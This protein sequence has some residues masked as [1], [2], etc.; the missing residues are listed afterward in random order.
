MNIKVK[1]KIIISV[2][3]IPLHCGAQEATEAPESESIR[4]KAGRYFH[5]LKDRLIAEEEPEKL[6][7]LLPEIH[8]VRFAIPSDFTRTGY[9]KFKDTVGLDITAMGSDYVKRLY[10][11]Q[12]EYRKR[13]KELNEND[14]DASFKGLGVK[15]DGDDCIFQYANKDEIAQSAFNSIKKLQGDNFTGSHFGEIKLPHKESSEDDG[16]FFGIKQ[17]SAISSFLK[18]YVDKK[19]EKL[20]QQATSILDIANEKLPISIQW[21]NSDYKIS[22]EGKDDVYG[23]ISHGGDSRIDSIGGKKALIIPF[24][25]IEGVKDVDTKKLNE[26]SAKKGKGEV[27]FYISAGKLRVVTRKSEAAPWYKQIINANNFSEWDLLSEGE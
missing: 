8:I 11:C 14:L 18:S 5:D 26:E 7:T 25:Y 27:A 13:M 17:D 12:I 15:I 19:T 24:S 1:E 9:E 21:D 23:Y 22:T 20:Q 4:E 3:L 10:A 6:E 2:I 16:L